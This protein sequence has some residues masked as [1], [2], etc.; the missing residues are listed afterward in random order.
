VDCAGIPIAWETT[1]TEILRL[2]NITLTSNSATITPTTSAVNGTTSRTSSATSTTAPP[3]GLPKGTIGGIAI[4]VILGALLFAGGMYLCWRRRRAKLRAAGGESGMPPNTHEL[5]TGS[6]AH[7]LMTKSN[8][9]ELPSKHGISQ[10]PDLK[11]IHIPNQDSQDQPR[12]A[13][14]ELPAGLHSPLFELDPTPSHLEN[15]S[16]E[17]DLA[18][19]SALIGEGSKIPARKPALSGSGESSQQDTANEAKEK[20]LKIL[21]ERIERIRRDKERLEQI[22][23]LTELEEATN[24]EILEAQS[25]LGG[26]SAQIDLL[27]ELEEETKDEIMETQRQ[28]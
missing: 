6:N 27:K 22:K 10:A 5:I 18:S 4:G 21:K 16:Q 13:Q 1:D 8:V 3:K 25:S 28:L 9:A 7:E 26:P 24:A 14:L 2:L 12:T 15:P 23:R 11:D 20:K 19:G 17:L